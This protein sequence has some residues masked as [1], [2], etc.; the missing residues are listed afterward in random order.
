MKL[1]HWTLIFFAIS[2][3]IRLIVNFKQEL[4]PGVNGGYYPLMVR[5][6]VLDGKLAFSD[7]P[8]LF[9][10]DWLI[11]KILTVFDIAT[12]DIAI[13]NVVKIV[14]S[15]SLPIMIFP[16][17]K[18]I[19]FS[20]FNNFQKVIMLAFATLSLSPLVLVSDLQ[21][22]A[23][24]ISFLAFH[25]YNLLLYGRKQENKRILYTLIFL[26]FTALTHFGT[27]AFGLFFTFLILFFWNL[28]KSFLP[29][30]LL[31]L[32]GLA[33]IYFYDIS[34]F[35]RLINFWDII[36]ERPAL[37]NNF[38]R[39]HDY[40]NILFSIY[41]SILGLIAIRKNPDIQPFQKS[42]VM[43][44]VIT[45]IIFSFPLL[46]G[47]YFRRLGF[48][49]FIVQLV[50]MVIINPFLKS[51]TKKITSSMLILLVLISLN[52]FIH[53][54]KESVISHEEFVDLKKISA[55]IEKSN[56]NIIISRHGLEWWVS[57]TL[58]AKVSQ[59]KAI[60]STLY[61]NYGNIYIINQLNNL[62]PL[63]FP[64]PFTE[65]RIP[66]N[67]TLTYSSDFFKLFKIDKKNSLLN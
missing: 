50:L 42:V 17:S 64:S 31:S 46:E 36:F 26:S 52:L 8:M 67:A 51:E 65:P 62:N 6:L 12:T 60:D 11:L 37:L 48:F 30:T 33:I 13:I 1:K 47:E 56:K 57:W 10:I 35:Q 54:N 49:L 16:L 24:A 15:L 34:R 14:D 43:A 66:T 53:H 18:V 25:F 29:I 2:F 20:N 40:L 4:V 3:A 23:L 44:S 45:L 32:S 61:E 27:F 39:P 19:N 59:E 63:N 7:M 41:L 28:K 58:N 55:N 9:Y 22:N 38:L 5:S 21:K